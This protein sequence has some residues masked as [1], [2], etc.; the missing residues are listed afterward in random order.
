MTLKEI[1][2]K[3]EKGGVVKLQV[4]H[5]I[6]NY[7]T[8]YVVLDFNGEYYLHRYFLSIDGW[9]VRKDIAGSPIERCLEEVTE[10]FKDIY[11]EDE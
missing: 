1:R 4:I 2:A 3:W 10:D 7:K 11:V 6:E 5:N 8:V 9:A